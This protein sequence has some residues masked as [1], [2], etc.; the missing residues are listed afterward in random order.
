MNALTLTPDERRQADRLAL[1]LA[2]L[3]RDTPG[4]T[5]LG[6]ST[7]LKRPFVETAIARALYLLGLDALLA[8]EPAAGTG[9]ETG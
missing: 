5:A 4:A 2:N 3:V 1:D 8:P 9:D 6:A 7:A